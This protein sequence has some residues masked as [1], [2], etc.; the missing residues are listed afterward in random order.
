MAG[1]FLSYSRKDSQEALALAGALREHG[2]EVWI[3]QEGINV[4]T[5]WS[6]E[7]ANAIRDAKVFTILLSDL[8]LGS[9]NVRKEIALASQYGTP[10]VPIDLR[11][12]T[13]PEELAEHFQ[14]LDH[15]HHTHL[16]KI[17]ERLKQFGVLGGAPLVSLRGPGSFSHD[18]RAERKSLMVLPFLDH[19][20]T[21]D[22][23]WFADGI[24]TELITALSKTKQLRLVDWSTTKEYKRRPVPVAQIADEL[25]VRY[26]VEGSVRTFG[27]QVKISV[28]L[29]DSDEESYLWNTTFKG[30]LSDIFE[31][32]EGV[33]SKVVEG[34][35][36]SLSASESVSIRERGT[37]N[38][39]AYQAWLKAQEQF[40]LHTKDAWL[41]SIILGKTAIRLDPEFL[42]ARV[43]TA[44]TLVEFFR[45]YD[46]NPDHLLEAEEECA[47]AEKI[48][49]KDGSR[50]SVLARI[51]MQRRE[52]DKALDLATQY[53]SGYPEVYDSHYTMALIS[54]MRGDAA[55][56]IKEYEAC[57]R[58]DP[59]RTVPYWNLVVACEQAGDL[60]RQRKWASA[61]VP[62]I[63]RRVRLNPEDENAWVWLTNLLFLAGEEEAS[64][65]QLKT[66][67]E[68]REAGP[69]YNLACFSER[70]HQH[71]MVIPFLR[72]SI[73]AG[74]DNIDMLEDG[75][76][77]YKDK[78][79]FRELVL[80]VKRRV[81]LK[82][83]S[84]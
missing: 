48:D 36:V 52:I 21:H 14:G 76:E 74:F 8:S 5:I 58:L 24:V 39:Q 79:E 10:I 41:E 70:V 18:Q 78:E 64:I 35:Q 57:V 22:N 11:P 30:E 83:S 6:T 68:I 17:L 1:V 54:Q 38:V 26:F 16:D 65:S 47:I 34:L 33:A 27:D 51:A 20:P 49:P 71:D 37:T 40:G 28:Q 46:R 45:L 29:L 84:A 73:A 19:S 61:A 56:A 44:S 63:E 75:W 13:I 32:Q 23:E 55:T 43:G 25:D 69:L 9:S 72:R 2:V 60:D 80:S 66:L 12:V 53:V 15:I 67:P 82:A 3:D 31:I 7:I 50:L 59:N 4:A 77:A 81:E 42:R 62:H